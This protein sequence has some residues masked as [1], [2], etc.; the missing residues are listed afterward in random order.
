METPEKIIRLIEYLSTLTKI[1]TRIVRTFD[2]Y[3]KILWVHDIP[4]EPKYCFTQVNEIVSAQ[5]VVLELKVN[6]SDM[7]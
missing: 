7:G 5:T 2:D 1:N 4:R 3:R 6:K